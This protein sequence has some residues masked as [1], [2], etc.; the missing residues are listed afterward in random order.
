MK[1]RNYQGVDINEPATW[2]QFKKHLCQDCQAG[3]C[4]LPV[5]VRTKDLVRMEIIDPFEADEPPKKIAQRLMKAGV[6]DH[7]NFKNT[8]FSLAR[9]ANDDCIYIDSAS[10]RCTIYE[11]RPDTCR[12]HPAIGPRSG[13]C[14]YSKQG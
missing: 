10:R 4:T 11:K 9:K 5:E 3:C 7:F 2:I 13:F 8:I 12:N 14:A 1:S 6:I